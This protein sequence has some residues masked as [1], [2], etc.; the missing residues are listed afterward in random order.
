M[1]AANPEARIYRI[2]RYRFKGRSRTLH[3]NVTLAEAQAHC[4]RPDTQGVRNGVR[5]F[6]G[7]DYMRGHAPS[8]CIVTWRPQGDDECK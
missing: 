5:W 7:Y 6:D 4:S 2:I 8:A 1:Q 3:K